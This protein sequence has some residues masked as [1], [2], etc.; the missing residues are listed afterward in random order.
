MISSDGIHI[1]GYFMLQD[2]LA[3]YYTP[4]LSGVFTWVK[5]TP[6][7]YCSDVVFS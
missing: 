4:S 5:R 2:S 3:T 6:V 7:N 1:F